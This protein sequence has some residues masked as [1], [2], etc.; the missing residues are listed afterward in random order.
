MEVA[1]PRGPQFVSG[2]LSARAQSPR[3]DSTSVC[4]LASARPQV[5]ASLRDG[6]PRLLLLP[7]WGLWSLSALH[8]W[9]CLKTASCAMPA[10]SQWD[11]CRHPRT[12]NTR[13]SSFTRQD[14]DAGSAH[15]RPEHRSDHYL[16]YLYPGFMH[17]LGAVSIQL[18]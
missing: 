10:R 17:H 9:T 2:C 12:R 16:L 13:P 15:A 18:A 3:P 7:C 1:Q 5:T 4:S 6:V 11:S 14:G 8:R